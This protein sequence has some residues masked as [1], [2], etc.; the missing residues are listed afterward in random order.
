[1]QADWLS[2]AK[3]EGCLNGHADLPQEFELDGEIAQILHQHERI[4]LDLEV[5]AKA[6][7]PDTVKVRLGDWPPEFSP[8]RCARPQR[9][10]VGVERRRIDVMFLTF[11][12][13]ISM[14]NFASPMSYMKLQV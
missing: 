12:S 10:I 7:R 5:F 14:M 3:R 2:R 8:A 11:P 1:M 9:E 4:A 13:C 6:C